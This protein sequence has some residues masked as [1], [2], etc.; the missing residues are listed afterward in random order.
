MS[1][2]PEPLVP[3]LLQAHQ[4]CGGPAHAAVIQDLSHGWPAGLHGVCGDEGSGKTSL[5]RLLADDLPAHSGSVRRPP[6]L[7][8]W[9]DLKGSEH[10]QTRVDDCWAQLQTRCPAWDQALLD[11]LS[12]ALDMERHRAK[13]LYMLSTGSRRKVMLIAALASGATVTLLDQPFVSLDQVS[14]RVIKSFLREAAQAKDRAWLLADY[15]MAADLPVAS[16]LYLP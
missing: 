9:A 11:D 5:L 16:V 4:L 14:V 10:D 15:E 13:P 12:Q 3:F 8:F 1:T 7:V 6:G 2:S